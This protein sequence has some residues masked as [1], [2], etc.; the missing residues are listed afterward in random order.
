MGLCKISGILATDTMPTVILD[1]LAVKREDNAYRD[2]VAVPG[3]GAVGSLFC[4]SYH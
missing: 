4:S 3:T 1:T 2:V